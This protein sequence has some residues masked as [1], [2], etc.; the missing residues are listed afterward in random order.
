MRTCAYSL[1]ELKKAITDFQRELQGTG[2]DDYLDMHAH[3]VVKLAMVPGKSTYEDHGGCFFLLV[4][5]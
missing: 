5:L 3:R 2:H 1:P 4:I